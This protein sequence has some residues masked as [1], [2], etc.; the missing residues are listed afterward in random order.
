MSGAR[1]RRAARQTLWRVVALLAPAAASLSAACADRADRRWDWERMRAQPRYEPYG[2]SAVF[3]DGKAMQEAPRGTVSRESADSAAALP[4][5]LTAAALVARG[6]ERFGIYCAP[7]HGERG[8]GDGLVGINMDPPPP[9][10]LVDVPRRALGA[11]RIYMVV[12]HGVGRM[13]PLASSLS[14]A[15]RWAVIAYVG[16]L[17]RAAVGTA[18][19][20]P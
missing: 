15:D 8:G 4:A 2:P 16:A 20:P 3:A 11:G 19:P 13:P 14:A 5:D 18:G 17:Q 1:D 12:T 9:P 6:G 7:C 10:S